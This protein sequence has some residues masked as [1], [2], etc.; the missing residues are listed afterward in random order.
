M[1]WPKTCAQC[2][3]WIFRRPVYGP[4]PLCERAPYH[5]ECCKSQAQAYGLD[6]NM[7]LEDVLEAVK[8][9]DGGAGRPRPRPRP[10]RLLRKRAIA[11]SWPKTC[12]QCG[13]WIFRRPVYGP[14]PLYER[15]PYH[16]ECCKSQAQAYGLD[17]NMPLEDVL[18]AVY[19]RDAGLGRA[20]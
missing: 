3:I 4:S 18:E 12:A 11:M 7:P 15:A 2:G 13:I 19:A 1:S 10:R 14:S 5:A 8:A 20:G 6:P 16:A 9:Q 17:P